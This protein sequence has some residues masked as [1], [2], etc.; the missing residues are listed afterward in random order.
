MTDAG[1][2][3]DFQVLKIQECPDA[4]PTGEV[5]RTYMVCCEK[6]LVDKLVPG[7][8]VTITGVYTI[9]ERKNP[10]SDMKQA[11]LRQ[12]YIICYSRLSLK[13]ASLARTLEPEEQHQSSTRLT[14][15][16]SRDMVPIQISIR[17]YQKVLVNLSS[18]MRTSRRPWLVCLWEAQPKFYLTSRD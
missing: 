9:I 7:T 5:P 2:F 15:T 18:V 17:R 4:I 16:G 10:S 12:P 8:R 3:T 13:Q 6:Y 1:E 14:S 11:G